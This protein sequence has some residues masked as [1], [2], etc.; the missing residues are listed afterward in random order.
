VT[1][2]L[3]RWQPDDLPLL[4][5]ANTPEMTR[6]LGGPETPEKLLERHEKYLQYWESGHAHMFRIDADGISVG[7][8]GWWRVEHQGRPA[9]ETGWGIEPEWQGRGIA[10]LALRRLIADVRADGERDLLVAYPGVDNPA[11]NALCR[12]AGFAHTGSETA[13][14]RGGELTFN[15]WELD[16][17]PLDLAGRRPEV[18]ERFAGAGLDLERWWP[19]YT[20]H[21]SSR[22]RA[23]ARFDIDGEGLTLRI[24]ADTAPWAPDLDGDLRVSHLQTGQ[25]SGPVGSQIGQHRFRPGL[26]VREQ[27]PE[28]RGWL[29]H[30]GVIEA[31]LAAIR[32]P[33]AMVALWPIGFEEQ[34]DECGEICIAEIFGSEVDDAGGWV[35]IGIKPQN[36]P[37]L[38]EDFEKVW[39]AGDLTALH[40]YAVEWTSEQ[41]RFF[42]DGQWVK[43]V[44]QSID[45]PV[46]LMLDVYRFPAESAE[47]DA[48]ALPHRFRVAHIR[49]YAPG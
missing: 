24:D 26:V 36:D 44:A 18:E 6:Y 20:P 13:P 14:W 41:V 32:H 5:R 11:S 30:H 46:Q 21:W 23:A 42:I 16:M 47:P 2:T 4:Q 38:R 25:R 7:S 49:T 28:H 45:Y 27:Q 34:P 33:A 31:R 1:V 19:F 3:S 40:D 37:R 17:S 43:T 35:G 22:E 29:V 39:V 8:I 15:I 10:R 12:G 9:Y 48:E